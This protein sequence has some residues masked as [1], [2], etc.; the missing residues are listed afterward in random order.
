MRAGGWIL[1]TCKGLLMHSTLCPQ[2]HIQEIRGYT[3]N[4]FHE[5]KLLKVPLENTGFVP[6]GGGE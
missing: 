5:M 4:D 6:R 1:Y 2:A 3:C